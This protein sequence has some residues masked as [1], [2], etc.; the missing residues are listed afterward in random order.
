[1]T[2]LKPQGQSI[3]AR[4]FSPQQT[5]IVDGNNKKKVY[6]LKVMI[7]KNVILCILEFFCDTKHNEQ[8]WFPPKS[9]VY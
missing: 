4:F 2:D 1:M 3:G 8:I 6:L 7:N 5:P 9:R